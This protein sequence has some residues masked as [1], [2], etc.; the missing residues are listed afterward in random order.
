MLAGGQAVTQSSCYS[1]QA[2]ACICSL[3]VLKGTLLF[4]EVPVASQNGLNGL[5]PQP[6]NRLAAVFDSPK[7][8]KQEDNP[9]EWH[10][11]VLA[12]VP[13]QAVLAEV[14]G[15]RAACN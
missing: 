6:A 4:P 14:T 10:K 15:K 9:R 12:L 1:Q 3:Q 2:F 13:S 7:P 5:T 11:A 8:S